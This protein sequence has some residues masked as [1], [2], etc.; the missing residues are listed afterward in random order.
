MA[1]KDKI[2]RLSWQLFESVK[3][4]VQNDLVN[5]IRAGQL[6]IDQAVTAQL[7]AVV[8]SSIEAA[9]MRGSKNFDKSVAVA[10]VDASMPDLK[11]APQA[12]KK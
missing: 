7:I 4:S 1:P 3:D 10:L 6:K 5:A 11:P 8:N 2:S 12:K 9:Y